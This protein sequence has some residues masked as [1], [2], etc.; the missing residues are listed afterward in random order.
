MTCE[1]PLSISYDGSYPCLCGGTLKVQIGDTEWTFPSHCLNSGGSVRFSN[2][3]SDVEVSQGPWSIDSEHYPVDFPEDRKS[4]LMDLINR[5]I[6][7][8]CCGGCV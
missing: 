2:D 3:Y 5:K 8:G 6:P 7:H 4:E 1:H